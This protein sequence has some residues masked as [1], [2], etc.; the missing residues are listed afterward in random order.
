ML[1]ACGGE[2]DGSFED[3]PA[4]AQ[5]LLTARA[6]TLTAAAD[7]LAGTPATISASS[8]QPPEQGLRAMAG[9]DNLG[10]TCY[11]N[12]AL[13]FLIHSIGPQRLTQHLQA[14]AADGDAQQREA[15]QGFMQLIADTC[16]ETGPTRQQ[17]SDFLA[18]VQQL[19][20]FSAINAD[21][22]LDFPIVGR[23]QDTDE[24]LMKLSESFQLHALYASEITQDGLDKFATEA[25]YWTILQPSSPDD[26][27]QAVLDQTP[28]AGWQ[29]SL[30]RPRPHLTVRVE[31]AVQDPQGL[32][33]LSHRNFDF[34]Q[35]VR[36]H[37]TEGDLTTIL[38]LEPREVIE[39]RGTDQ[40]GHY[41]VY[42]KDEQWVRYDDAQVTALSQ[43]PALEQV[44]FINFAIT[45]I[46]TASSSPAADAS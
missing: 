31:N 36:L 28:A 46:E 27:L 39:F 43:M 6:A 44:R 5:T 30:Q 25:Q 9:F 34:H 42:A 37:A 21:N 2:A 18:A 14:F 4:R 17:L 10:S 3:F 20:A 12:A 7:T 24:F 13:K 19:P 23:Q 32:R 41:V 11:A 33:P 26:T 45:H 1:A 8:M 22:A 35:T 38:T 29:L 40:A 15:A 16:S